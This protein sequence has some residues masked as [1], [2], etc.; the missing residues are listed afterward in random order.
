MAL[1]L[2]GKRA[3][4][5]GGSRNLGRA[6][7]LA[8]ARA[9]ARVALTYHQRADDAEETRRL[10]VEAGVA[11]PLVFQGSVADAA[12]ASATVDA[13]GRAWGGVDIL[14]CNAALTQVLPI[15]LVDEAD[16]DQVMDVNVKGT[17]L[18]ARAA[19]RPMIKQRAGHILCVGSFGADRVVEAPVH[20]AASKAALVG[21]T[22]ALAKEV[23]RYGVRV[24][25][26]VP[27]LL[28]AGLSS[29]LPRHRT[30][31]YLENCALGRLGGVAELAEAA[32]W[33]VSSENSFMTGAR[34]IVD[35][36]L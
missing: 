12:H 32:T 23:G 21:F 1:L 11:E 8:F 27:G 26:L 13:L 5:T 36:G 28:E 24:N 18:F 3:L 35:G 30:Q 29:R 14:V 17:Y 25:L 9:G 10:L 16:W 31:A 7:C 22:T 19:L 2:E 6:L 15:A 20:Y 33:L 34:V 4:V